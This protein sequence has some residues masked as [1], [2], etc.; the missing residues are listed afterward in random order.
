MGRKDLRIVE[1][2]APEPRVPASE[3]TRRELSPYRLDAHSWPRMYPHSDQTVSP[4]FPPVERMP[5]PVT[6]FPN[7]FRDDPEPA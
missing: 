4:H 5:V 2:S 6:P 7:L 3:E 1:Y